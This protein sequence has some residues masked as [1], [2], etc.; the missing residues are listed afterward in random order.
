MN[1]NLTVI[2][3]RDLENL[4]LPDPSLVSYYNH[5]AKR[6][7]WIEG[8]IGEDTDEI[9]QQ[10]MDCN[11]EDAEK[12]V[13][14]RIPIKLFINT[15][16]GDVQTMWVLINAIK[17]SETPVHTIAFNRAMSAGAQILASGHK[18]FAFRGAV[19]LFHSGSCTLDGD[20]EKVESARKYF[21]I[22]S[23]EANTLLFANTDIAPKTL[24]TKG[25]NDWYMTAEEALKLRVIDKI[26][27][28]FSEVL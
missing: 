19:I 1:E 2:V 21:D 3:P 9:I 24:K 28:D 7:F 23:K 6:M 25:A 5:T 11:L 12:P 20:M 26:I 27:E 18:R 15:N 16:G 17:I 4:R 10:I 14:E 13:S 8:I 22:I